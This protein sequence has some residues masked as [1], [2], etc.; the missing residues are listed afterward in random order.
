[1][2]A[3]NTLPNELSKP[4]AK[5]IDLVEVSEDLPFEKIW[6]SAVMD[7]ADKF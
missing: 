1:M 3:F 2:P 4:G 5:V 6:C 7:W